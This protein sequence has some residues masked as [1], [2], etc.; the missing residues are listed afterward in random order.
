[1]ASQKFGTIHHEFRVEP[2]ALDILPQLVWHYDEPFADSSAIPTWYLSQMTR[3]HVTVAL[4][5]DGA[6]ELFA[7]YPRHYG[8]RL[9]GYFDGLPAWLRWVIS[10]PLCIFFHRA[11]VK[12]HCVA[13]LADSWNSFVVARHAGILSGVCVWPEYRNDLYSDEFIARWPARSR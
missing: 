10:E 9:A 4:T 6:D 1:M 3:R 2:K 11:A 5:G 8:M 7:V 13:A 12:S